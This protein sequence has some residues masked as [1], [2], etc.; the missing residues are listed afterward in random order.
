MISVSKRYV[1]KSHIWN[2]KQKE[3]VRTNSYLKLQHL[4]LYVIVCLCAKEVCWFRYKCYTSSFQ[5]HLVSSFCFIL[6]E[7][8]HSD[9]FICGWEN[10]T[11]TD[12][13]P[14]RN[15]LVLD[16]QVIVKLPHASGEKARPWL[17]KQVGGGR[18]WEKLCLYLMGMVAL[19]I[20]CSGQLSNIFYF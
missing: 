14:R 15:C 3:R 9:H 18:G 7:Q 20:K 19:C 1:F 11:L 8:I 5:S 6:K 17:E 2:K 12:C 4:Y 10:W 16:L 13:S